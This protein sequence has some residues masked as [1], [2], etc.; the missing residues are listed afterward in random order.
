MLGGSD[1]NPIIKCDGVHDT[2]VGYHLLCLPERL[3]EVPKDAWFCPACRD[4]GLWEVQEVLGKRKR[5]GRVQYLLRWQAHPTEEFDTWEPLANVPTAS[6][7][8]INEFR[9][10][11]RAANAAA[12]AAAPAAAARGGRGRGGKGATAGRAA[13]RGAGRGRA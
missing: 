9:A 1:D 4:N 11:E 12:P 13:G 7:E 10:K 3:D 5:N 2:E 8:M 6:R